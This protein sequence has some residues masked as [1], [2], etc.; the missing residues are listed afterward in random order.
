M[1]GRSQ[2]LR[3]FLWSLS[4][5]FLILSRHQKNALK[6]TKN[7]VVIYSVYQQVSDSS[8][9]ASVRPDRHCTTRL[10]A[11]AADINQVETRRDKT[12][13]STRASHIS[14]YTLGCGQ[15]E[16]EGSEKW[17][18]IEKSFELTLICGDSLSGEQPKQSA[19]YGLWT[20][21]LLLDEITLHWN[22]IP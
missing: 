17:S 12:K 5:S 2:R 8:I 10:R 21:W 4:L 7:L 18:H 1:F 9:K 22:N 20:W 19:R 11:H 15:R 14:L 3:W 13:R 6:Q 16:W